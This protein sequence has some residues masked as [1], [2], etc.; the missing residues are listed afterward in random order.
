MSSFPALNGAPGIDNFQAD[1]N[2]LSA[3]ALAYIQ[4]N[5]GLTPPVV[6][7]NTVAA[8]IPLSVVGAAAQSANLQEWRD[9]G[10]SELFGVG[11]TGALRLGGSNF[12]VRNSGVGAMVVSSAGLS[13]MRISGNGSTYIDGSGFGAGIQVDASAVAGNTRLLVYDVDNG[14]LERVTVGAADSG[15]VGFKVLRIPN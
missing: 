7:T 5:V 1:F 13:Q 8:Q 6:L 15:G 4:A 10:G 2:S 12:A 9:N 11:A 3:R 14:A